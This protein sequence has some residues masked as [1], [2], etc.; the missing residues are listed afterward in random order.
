MGLKIVEVVEGAAL[1]ETQEPSSI[2]KRSGR[3]LVFN[4]SDG[5]GISRS[6]WL[7]LL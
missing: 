3:R 7:N 6:R 5:L 2:A 4:S 1:V